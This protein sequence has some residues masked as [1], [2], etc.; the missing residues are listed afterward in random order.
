MKCDDGRQAAPAAAPNGVDIESAA[1]AAPEPAGLLPNAAASAANGVD[2]QMLYQRGREVFESM[3]QKGGQIG[4]SLL[5][6]GVSLLHAMG[7]QCYHVSADL[8]L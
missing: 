2:H 1:A 4:V 3:Q 5:Q 6:I 8:P 7:C